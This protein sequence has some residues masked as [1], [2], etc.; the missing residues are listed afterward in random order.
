MGS[1]NINKEYLLNYREF[2]CSYATA[3][4]EDKFFSYNTLIGKKYKGKEDKDILFVNVL[5]FSQS[6][7]THLLK[8]VD[9]AVKQDFIVIPFVG[10]KDMRNITVEEVKADLTRR[11]LEYTNDDN[12]GYLRYSQTK[13]E[14][15]HLMSCVVQFSTYI[16]PLD[17]PHLAY[18]LADNLYDNEYASKLPKTRRPTGMEIERIVDISDYC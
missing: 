8:L 14:F 3:F 11:V 16:E 6:S 18:E 15:T 2:E 7:S 9:E 5:W 1:L 12:I 10:V 4:K 17:I 13:K